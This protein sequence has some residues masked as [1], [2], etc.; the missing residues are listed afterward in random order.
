MWPASKRFNDHQWSERMPLRDRDRQTSVC[1]LQEREKDYNA[2][3]SQQVGSHIEEDKGQMWKTSML[4]P[5]RNR[6]KKKITKVLSV[7]GDE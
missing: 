5:S 2:L 3:A 4:Q 7:V 1:R 6:K